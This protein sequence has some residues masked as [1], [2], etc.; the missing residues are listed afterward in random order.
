MMCVLPENGIE[1]CVKTT[2]SHFGKVPIRVD[3]LC[4][5]DLP[6]TFPSQIQ[7]TSLHLFKANPSIDEKKSTGHFM[8]DN[9]FSSLKCSQVGCLTV[10]QR[11][12]DSNKFNRLL[13][14]CAHF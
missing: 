8:W 13:G 1:L 6:L 14:N 12:R 7:A 2:D 9:F 3:D 4:S 11:H 10:L 5:L